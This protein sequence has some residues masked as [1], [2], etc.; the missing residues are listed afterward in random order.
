MYPRI[1]NA[2]PYDTIIQETYDSTPVLYGALKGQQ[3]RFF[4]SDQCACRQTIK[5]KPMKGCYPTQLCG[6]C[7]LDKAAECVAQHSNNTFTSA[8]S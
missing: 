7:R 3:R 8:V 4:P 2:Y 5:G 6:D 1:G